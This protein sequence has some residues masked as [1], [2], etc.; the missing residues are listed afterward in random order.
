MSAL[1]KACPTDIEIVRECL[2]EMRSIR[3]E[4]ALLSMIP[5]YNLEEYE[6]GRAV[7]VTLEA[8]YAAAKVDPA[9]WE[10]VVTA[11]DAFIAETTGMAVE[12]VRHETEKTAQEVEV[13][14]KMSEDTALA[15]EKT[16]QERAA[17]TAKLAAF[18][19]AKKRDETKTR[20]EA[21]MAR[22][23][24]A[25][26]AANAEA[27]AELEAAESRARTRKMNSKADEANVHRKRMMYDTYSWFW[28][29]RNTIDDVK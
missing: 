18:A 7:A 22:D 15:A 11:V 25:R 4:R 13:T 21:A 5:A 29:A 1:L 24:L 27:K 14:K 2:T 10:R 17:T 6:T 26:T 8:Y 28:R 23:E 20:H 16:K 9:L 3:R 12:H 19:E